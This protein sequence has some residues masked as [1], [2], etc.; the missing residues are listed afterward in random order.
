MVDPT[1]VPPVTDT[2]SAA[3]PRDTRTP[4]PNDIGHRTFL[5]AFNLKDLVALH[6][7]RPKTYFCFQGA[8]RFRIDTVACHH[9][10][11]FAV[12]SYH[13]L[14]DTV[15]SDHH[16]PILFTLIHPVARLDKS[17]SNTVCRTPEYY[18]GPVALSDLQ[19]LALRRRCIDPQLA[20]TRW[21]T[22]LQRAIYE[23][24]HAAGRV[25]ALHFRHYRLRT[26]PAERASPRKFPQ[27]CFAAR[28]M[29]PS[30]GCFTTAAHKHAR[31][32]CCGEARPQKESRSVGWRSTP[33]E[34]PGYQAPGPLENL[35]DPESPPHPRALA[36][37]AT[38]Q[39]WPPA[40]CLGNPLGQQGALETKVH[41]VYTIFYSFVYGDIICDERHM[42]CCR[43][44]G[45]I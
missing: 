27:P 26:G 4:R 43:C 28:S 22:G 18:L 39:P 30:V 41:L 13:Y 15:L 7:V 20:S 29:L 36:G 23:W 25:R 32:L 17:N 24:A 31:Q 5:R 38:A 33:A 12:A 6:P 34:P 11:T 40:R 21:L 16:T 44:A 35:G 8:A 37:G 19:S 3:R 2:N 42:K 14:G 10:A 9:E 1:S 45:R